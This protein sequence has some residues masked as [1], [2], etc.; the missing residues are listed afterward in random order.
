MNEEKL[1]RSPK[2]GGKR[3]GR[4]I[5][6]VYPPHH[7]F[8][9]LATYMQTLTPIPSDKLC[10]YNNLP[11][12]RDNIMR[13]LERHLI[14]NPGIVN[15]LLRYSVSSTAAKSIARKFLHFSHPL[16]IDALRKHSN[17]IFGSTRGF[18][19]Q[20]TGTDA[21]LKHTNPIDTKKLVD[22]FS[23]WPPWEWIYGE[24]M[25]KKNKPRTTTKDYFQWMML[26]ET[27]AL[28]MNVIIH[29]CS[30][31]FDFLCIIELEKKQYSRHGS[32]LL[33]ALASMYGSSEDFQIDNSMVPHVLDSF[34]ENMWPSLLDAIESVA[35][36]IVTEFVNGLSD[37]RVI[38]AGKHKKNSKKFCKKDSGIDALK[39]AEY[40]FEDN[41]VS[42]PFWTTFISQLLFSLVTT[43]ISTINSFQD[44]SMS[45]SYYQSVRV[46]L[47]HLKNMT[48]SDLCRHSVF[49]DI[50]GQIGR[51]HSIVSEKN[52]ESWLNGILKVVQDSPLQHIDREQMNMFLLNFESET[53]GTVRE[54]EKVTATYLK[55][56]YNDVISVLKPK[57][58]LCVKTP[59]PTE[60]L[61]TFGCCKSCKID[62]TRVSQGP[63]VYI[64]PPTANREQVQRHMDELS[65]QHNVDLSLENKN[66]DRSTDNVE[67]ELKADGEYDIENEEGRTRGNGARESKN[68]QSAY[69]DGI[70]S[71]NSK[72]SGGVCSESSGHEDRPPEDDQLLDSPPEQEPKSQTVLE[73]D[74]Q[75]ADNGSKKRSASDAFSGDELCQKRFAVDTTSDAEISVPVCTISM[76]NTEVPEVAE[77][78]HFNFKRYLLNKSMR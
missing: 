66:V 68:D 62:W 52:V 1:T 44:G 61:D 40:L 11:E 12:W 75:R 38:Y 42:R 41:S 18:L 57:Q 64:I 71:E 50:Q 51:L 67:G 19:L 77:E 73:A 6:G 20:V 34:R 39:F 48:L 28:C 72:K 76:N 69:L 23:T 30:V 58:V 16:C 36:D 21:R 29:S 74:T 5:E 24:G 32:E 56:T 47:R 37:E 60:A 9:S 15:V 14:E 65:S 70:Q 31:L 17:G 43:G 4:P 54:P 45:Q 10:D 2:E 49:S 22:R 33:S 13:K 46:I 53:N 27:K 25:V 59:P 78:T 8:S 63:M 3:T 35:A 55:L 7:I 26:P